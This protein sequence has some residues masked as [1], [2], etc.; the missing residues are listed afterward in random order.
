[1]SGLPLTRDGPHSSSVDEMIEQLQKVK[2]SLGNE[3]EKQ[4][5]MVILE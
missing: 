1:V 2:Q 4:F 5:K 3:M